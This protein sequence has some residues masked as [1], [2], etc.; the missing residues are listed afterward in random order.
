MRGPKPPPGGGAGITNEA[1]SD[2]AGER[3][4]VAPVSFALYGILIAGI[5]LAGWYGW[6]RLVLPLAPR[7]DPASP[8]A[9]SVFGGLDGRAVL[10]LRLP[11]L[12]GLRQLVSRPR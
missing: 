8:L 6:T 9:L 1:R 7:I 5:G 12:S 3:R 10:A 4:S 11:A 2:A